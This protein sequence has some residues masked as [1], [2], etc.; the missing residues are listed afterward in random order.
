MAFDNALRI[1][2]AYS[3]IHRDQTTA[4]LSIH[5][6]V[7]AVLTDTMPAKTKKQW[8]KRVIQAVNEAFPAVTFEAWTRCGR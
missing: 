6:L 4:T 2:L 1:L 5:R 8:R 7:Q 3:L